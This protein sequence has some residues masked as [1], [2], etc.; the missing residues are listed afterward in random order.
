MADDEST[1]T[2]LVANSGDDA[3]VNFNSIKLYD[4]KVTSALF[5][6]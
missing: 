4:A 6:L 1:V 2:T 3:K 5:P